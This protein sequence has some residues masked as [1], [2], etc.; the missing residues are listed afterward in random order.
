MNQAGTLHALILTPLVRPFLSNFQAGTLSDIMRVF[1]LFTDKTRLFVIGW[2]YAEHR[3]SGWAGHGFY[4][5]KAWTFHTTITGRD[6]LT[7]IRH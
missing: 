7:T 5:T 2:D 3:I 1:N 6:R 4:R